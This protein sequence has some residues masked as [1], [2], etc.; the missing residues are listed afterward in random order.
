MKKS[1]VQKE[2]T[3]PNSIGVY[4]RARMHELC[5]ALSVSMRGLDP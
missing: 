5:E 3:R 1:K 4:I 2:G